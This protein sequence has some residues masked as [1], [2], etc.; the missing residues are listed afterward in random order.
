[1]NA[2]NETKVL[3]PQTT[4]ARKVTPARYEAPRITR[5]QSLERVTLASGAIAPGGAIGGD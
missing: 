4:D 2:K 1:M 5:K 3:E